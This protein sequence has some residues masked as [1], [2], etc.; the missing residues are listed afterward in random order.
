MSRKNPP[1]KKKSKKCVIF[2]KIYR[3]HVV[4]GGTSVRLARLPSQQDVNL[5]LDPVLVVRGVRV[6]ALLVHQAGQIGQ[7]VNEVEQL[8]DV[9]GDRS[10]LHR[11]AEWSPWPPHPS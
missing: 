8:T 4:V 6:R 7:L 10:V 5:L 2:T 9:V 1:N 11:G 3:D